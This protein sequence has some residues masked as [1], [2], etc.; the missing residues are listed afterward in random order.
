MLHGLAHKFWLSLPDSVATS[1][2]RERVDHVLAQLD[3]STESKIARCLPEPARE[4][5]RQ[6]VTALRAWE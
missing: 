6:L 2:L 1:Y 5:F 3:P 4:P